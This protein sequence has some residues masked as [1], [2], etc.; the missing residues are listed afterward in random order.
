M[1]LKDIIDVARLPTENGTAL[2]AGKVPDQDAFVVERL[3]Q[4]G[5][6]IMGK[7]VT[8]ELAYLHPGKT[9]N[10]HNLS[11]TPGGSSSGSAAAVADAMVPLAIGTQTGGSVIR[12]ASFCGITGFKP[13]FGSIPRRGVLAQSP[14]LDTVGVFAADPLGA[15]LL[16]DQLFGFDAHDRATSLVP[17]PRLLKTASAGPPLEPVFAVLRPHGWDDADPELHAG[18]A[19]LSEALGG[20]AF[21]IELPKLFEQ[22]APQRQTVNFAEM[23]RHYHRYW[24]KAADRLGEPTRAAI[25]EGNAITARD[26][27]AALDLCDVFN[28]GLG[29]IFERCDA[30]LSPSALGPAPDG[31][32]STG[33]SVFNALWTFC[34]T[35]ALSLPLL[36]A[37]SGLPMGVQLAG[38]RGNDGRL[39]R[40]AQWLFD[41]ADGR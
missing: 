25:E 9:R 3:K 18:F 40:T 31:L 33:D 15:A 41:W 16:A 29:E 21:D 14:T 17:A 36:T 26:Y 20:Q 37:S 23:A 11:H 34:G 38:A 22:A 27:L 6:V 39:L 19:E 5:A 24:R 30:I 7:T 12:P 35:P 28:A 1:G 32:G 10:P 4:S 13:T 8:A 2:D